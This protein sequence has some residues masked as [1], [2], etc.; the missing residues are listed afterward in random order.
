MCEDQSIYWVYILVCKNNAYYTGYTNN[1]IKRYKDHVTGR[2]KCKYT[3]SFKPIYLA[4][5]WIF[6]DKGVAMKVE[7]AIKKLARNQKS[8]LINFPNLISNLYNE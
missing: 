5:S 8:N 7:N 1:L 4:Q 3:R 2:G 6:K